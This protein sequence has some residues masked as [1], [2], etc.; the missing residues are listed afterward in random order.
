MIIVE[1]ETHTAGKSAG[2]S[3]RFSSRVKAYPSNEVP[4]LLANRDD[5]ALQI[6]RRP[7]SSS[8]LLVRTAHWYAE[9]VIATLKLTEG[10][11]G[12]NER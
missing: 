5:L 8:T 11:S 9:P 3:R 12:P 7:V 10:E 4:T 1:G 2:L 6:R